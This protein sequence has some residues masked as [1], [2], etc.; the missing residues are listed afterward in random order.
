MSDQEPVKKPSIISEISQ[1]REQYLA[2]SHFVLDAVNRIA[3]DQE[4]MRQQLTQ[5][6]E[7]LRRQVGQI[8]TE[9]TTVKTSLE[10]RDAVEKE[11]RSERTSSKRY[12]ISTLIAAT[13]VFI[14]LLAY[15]SNRVPQS[16]QTT[17]SSS[18]TERKIK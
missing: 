2:D 4:T 9:L 18:G 10:V 8:S 6:H 7:E 13:A 5:A 14:A 17:Q 15:L 3:N 1:F 12:L 11:V 16:S